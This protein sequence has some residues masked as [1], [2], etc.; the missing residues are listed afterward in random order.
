MALTPGQIDG[1]VR[2]GFVVVS[3]AIDPDWCEEQVQHG[4]RRLG[5]DENDP[6]SFDV[7]RT[8]MPATQGF[9]CAEHAPAAKA[10][11][12]QLLGG[13]EL[14]HEPMFTDNFIMVLPGEDRPWK[15]PEAERGGWHKDGDWFLHFFDSPEQAILGIIFW[16]DIEPRGGGT[17]FAPDSI[18]PVA[19]KLL[20]HPEG[21]RPEHFD[22]VALHGECQDFRELTGRAGDVVWMHPYMLHSISSNV[23]NRPRVLSNTSSSLAEPMCFERADGA[24][25][26]V[27]RCVLRA[28]DAEQIGFEATQ[29][30]ERIHPERE[31]EWKRQLERERRRLRP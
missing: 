11:L 18:G 22:F 19:R 10:A 14:A 28:L 20:A 24:Y 23:S 21:L 8:H 29:P 31:K 17:Y 25:S 13:R 2:D 9:A 27:E 3:E 4:F 7:R 1:F 15:P 12:E 5:I 6:S 16:R 26:P 30:R